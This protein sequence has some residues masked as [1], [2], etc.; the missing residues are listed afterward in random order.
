MYYSLDLNLGKSKIFVVIFCLCTFV[1]TSKVMAQNPDNHILTVLSSDANL[2]SVRS[3][4]R[5]GSIITSMPNNTSVN[6]SGTAELIAI[7]QAGKIFVGW[8]DNV[9]NNPRTVDVSQDMTFTAIFEECETA[10]IV[11]TIESPV[12]FKIYPNVI[13]YDNFTVEIDA[14]LIGSVLR[15]YSARGQ[16]LLQQTL[17]SQMEIISMQNYANGI[18]FVQLLNYNG[19]SLEAI[20]VSK[21]AKM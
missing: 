20:C 16:L 1:L 21:L 13:V 7:P 18:Y 9:L 6:F 11:G 19:E 5:S 8:S 4:S 12:Y 15:I 10:D 17:L 3:Y 2:G 14:S